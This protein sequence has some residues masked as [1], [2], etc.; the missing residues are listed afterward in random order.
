MYLN[1][2]FTG[3][4]LRPREVKRLLKYT[5]QWGPNFLSDVP[6]LRPHPSSQIRV[7]TPPRPLSQPGTQRRVSGRCSHPTKYSLVFVALTLAT[8]FCT[9]VTSPFLT[10][11]GPVLDPSFLVPGLDSGP[12]VR[13]EQGNW[14]QAKMSVGAIPKGRASGGGECVWCPRQ[15]A[16]LVGVGRVLLQGA[17]ELPATSRKADL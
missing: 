1:F 5:R 10:G 6:T 12:G 16:S 2:Y 7:T 13:A 9:P 8:S 17:S 15:R 14:L 3:E 11:S 4:K